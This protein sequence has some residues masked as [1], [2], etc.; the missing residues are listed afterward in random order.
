MLRLTGSL[1]SVVRRMA[2]AG[3]NVA[4]VLAAHGST[5]IS[6]D[7]CMTMPTPPPQMAA[8]MPGAAAPPAPSTPHVLEK[9]LLRERAE[10]AQKTLDRLRLLLLPPAMLKQRMP[11]DTLLAHAPRVELVGDGGA[12]ID[13]TTLN[14]T[15][16]AAARS[17]R[18]E[19]CDKEVPVRYNLPTV[20]GVV[21]PSVVFVGVPCVCSNVTTMFTSE[22]DLVHEWVVAGDASG[23][24]LSKE[25]VVVPPAELAGKTL[26]Y[27]VR[28][29]VADALWTEVQTPPVLRPEKGFLPQPRWALLPKRAQPTD[30]RVITYNIL[31]DGFCNGNKG[32]RARIYPFCTQDILHIDYRR[33][34]IA[35]ELLVYDADVACLQEVGKDVWDRYLH[36]VLKGA[37]YSARLALK[38]GTAREGCALLWKAAAFDLERYEEVALNDATLRAHHPELAA[39]IEQ[40]PHFMHAMERVPSVAQFA[41][42]R[43]KVDGRRMV[44]G[45]T[46]LYYHG[47]ANHVRAIQCY[48]YAAIARRFASGTS[49]GDA[50]PTPNV[51]AAAA[52]ASPPPAADAAT[53][54]PLLPILL[55]G[56]LNTSRDV[57][58]Y[59]LLVSEGEVPATSDVWDCGLK[60]YWHMDDAAS[61]DADAEASAAGD[62]KSE[63]GEED[64][65][66]SA[67]DGVDDI[68]RRPPTACFRGHLTAPLVCQDAYENDETLVA[69]NFTM[70]FR[71]VLDHILLSGPCT[72]VATLPPPSVAEMSKD[73][74]LPSA[75]F[76]SDHIALLAHVR[77]Q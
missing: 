13:G 54:A 76:P 23:R 73:V 32:A 51:A 7:L 15:A 35:Q 70:T 2:S 22:N 28:P 50:L 61:P 48:L 77:L 74:A 46:H 30:I 42:L 49:D 1:H 41:V 40:H 64:P 67:A 75:M 59:E 10:P 16:W 12:V 45:N 44:V 72:A 26:L 62:A 20:T 66:K 39:G 38:K 5:M 69:T 25:P 58:G 71:D 24:V 68:L 55:L 57:A 14:E 43:R 52:A 60:Y 3:K 36:P 33:A 11:R 6:I 63:D 47:K 8:V 31:H 56:D 9:N 4:V 34:R 17:L 21:P 37:G 19:G 65:A 53:P 29:N 27:R 18:V